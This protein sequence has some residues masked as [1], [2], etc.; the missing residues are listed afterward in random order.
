MSTFTTM[1]SALK[2]RS[3][4]GKTGFA[5]TSHP[6]FATRARAQPD[7]LWLSRRL[8]VLSFPR[9][10]GSNDQYVVGKTV[11]GGNPSVCVY[12]GAV[13]KLVLRCREQA[14]TAKALHGTLQDEHEMRTATARDVHSMRDLLWPRL[15]LVEVPKRQRVSFHRLHCPGSRM[16][17]VPV[18][19]FQAFVAQRRWARGRPHPPKLGH[20]LTVTGNSVTGWPVA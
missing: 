3:K 10:E 8:A 6:R 9:S 14:G 18:G 7:C 17:G 1:I 11:C 12:W 15:K 13:L 16:V 5:T 2:L 20:V 4:M 19:F